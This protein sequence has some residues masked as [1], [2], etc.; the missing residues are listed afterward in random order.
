M[1]HDSQNFNVTPNILVTGKATNV[2]FGRPIEMD[3][4]NKYCNYF[5][6]KGAWPCHATGLPKF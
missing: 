5:F 1:S 6:H 3:S 4:L 2:K